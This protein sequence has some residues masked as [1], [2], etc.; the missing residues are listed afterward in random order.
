MNGSPKRSSF[1]VRVVLFAVLSTCTCLTSAGCGLIGTPGNNS[2]FPSL[3]PS[4]TETK[5]FREMVE[6]DPFPTA[7]EAGVPPYED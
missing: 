7:Q 1:S 4:E 6:N 5:A 2:L 3:F